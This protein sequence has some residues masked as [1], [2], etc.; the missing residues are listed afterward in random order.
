MAN[1]KFEPQAERDIALCYLCGV[2]PGNRSFDI[3]WQIKES[4][5]PQ[6][7]LKRTNWQD[8]LV[9]VY[10]GRNK[11]AN[12]IHL[13][14]NGMNEEDRPQDMQGGLIDSDFDVDTYQ[15]SSKVVRDFFR[16]K[17]NKTIEDMG[18]SHMFNNEPSGYEMLERVAT[19]NYPENPDNQASDLLSP[20]I[21]E[22]LLELYDVVRERKDSRQFSG[23]GLKSATPEDFLNRA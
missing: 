17:E 10:K 15:K 6:T 21:H 8:D 4:T 7:I 11:A 3:N 12:A 13:Y 9:D 19:K 2:G 18:L 22:E 14:F 1:R 20:V 5:I 23:Y 16:T